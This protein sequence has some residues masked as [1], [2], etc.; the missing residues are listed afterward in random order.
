M[1]KLI[2]FEINSG[3]FGNDQ[4]RTSTKR[5]TEPK[6]HEFHCTDLSCNLTLEKVKIDSQGHFYSF[7]KFQ[8]PGRPWPEYLR[9]ISFPKIL[10]FQM[11]KIKGS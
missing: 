4:S 3:Q 7:L 8:I 10:D 9:K 6:N 1:V 5:R 11:N 2:I